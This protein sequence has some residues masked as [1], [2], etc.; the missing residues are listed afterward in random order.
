MGWGFG[1][2]CRLLAKRDVDRFRMLSSC[3]R[4]QHPDR[5]GCWLMVHGS[6]LKAHGSWPRGAGPTPGPRGAARGAGPDRAAPQGSR[7]GQ[8]PLGHEP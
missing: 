3:G 6:W 2:W 1:E 5:S 7:A 8:A 4:P